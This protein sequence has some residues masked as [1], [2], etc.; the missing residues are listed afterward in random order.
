M[1]SI[2]AAAS[3][4]GVEVSAAEVHSK[5]E[6]EGAIAAQGIK[7]GGGVIVTPDPFNAANRDLII[8]L[9]ARYRV[10][11]IYFNRF[12]ADSGGLIVYGSVFTEEFRQAA[13]YI[14]LVLKGEKLVD[15]PMQ[16]PTNY[17]LVINLKT[18]KALGLT[19]PASLL[20]RAN[21][22]IE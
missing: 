1:P 13:D 9:A 19:V 10:P 11:T 7:P 12:F 17:E 3:S 2:Q 6:I 18:A 8:A 14:D 20:A 4:F 22:V 5:D 21:A 15:L 16:A